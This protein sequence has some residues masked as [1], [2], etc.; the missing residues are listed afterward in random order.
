MKRFTQISLTVLL[1]LGTSTTILAE[2]C[3]DDVYA[4]L[5]TS[6]TNFSNELGIINDK[7]SDPGKGLDVIGRTRRGSISY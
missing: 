7:L 6:Q 2:F 4:D 1:T 5:I 3:G